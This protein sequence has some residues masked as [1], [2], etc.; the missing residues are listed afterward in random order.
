MDK[1]LFPI[2]IR[3]KFE[4]AEELG[5]LDKLKK[6][7]WKGLSASETGKI[8]A[9]MKARLKEYKKSEGNS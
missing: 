5:L 3:L 6:L 9:L 8:G 1:D 2:D 4:A 7:G